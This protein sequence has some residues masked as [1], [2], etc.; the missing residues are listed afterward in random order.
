MSYNLSLYGRGFIG[1]RYDEM[2]PGAQVIARECISCV[3]PKILNFRSTIHNYY[4][5]DGNPYLD[6]ETNLLNFMKILDR[7]KLSFKQEAEINHISSWFVLG[8]TTCP[9]NERD[10]CNPKGFY[11]ITKRASEQLLISYCETF[12]GMNYRI[13]RL[14]NVLGVGDEKISKRKNAL[15]YMVKCIVHDEPINI[16]EED[17]I[18]DYIW[19]DDVCRAIHIA[20]TKGELNTIYH[21]GNG[22]PQS[23]HNLLDYVIDVTQYDRSKI[24]YVPVPE[25][26]KTVQVKKMYMDNQKITRLGYKP[27]KSIYQVLDELI[28]YYGRN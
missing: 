10:Y 9:A 18:R 23:L 27:S 4:P 26:H 25:F 12:K 19:V 17:V 28:E 14:A 8:D 11:S 1:G 2:F 7:A 13:L 22:L 6:I 15:Q 5:I 21:L 16:Y 20:I 3:C 24:T